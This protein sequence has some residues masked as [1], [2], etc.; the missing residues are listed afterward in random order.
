[1]IREPHIYKYFTD[2]SEQKEANWENGLPP[3][4]CAGDN[5]KH[6]QKKKTNKDIIEYSQE[7]PGT[8]RQSPFPDEIKSQRQRSK[9]PSSAAGLAISASPFSLYNQGPA[10]SI[11]RP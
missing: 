9:C 7:H 11:I 5:G 4:D 6:E 2:T 1:M 10:A 3:A 8:A